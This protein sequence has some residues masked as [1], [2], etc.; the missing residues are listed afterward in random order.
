M[1][2]KC[3]LP[4]LVHISSQTTAAWRGPMISPRAH[5]AAPQARSTSRSPACH[6]AAPLYRTRQGRMLQPSQDVIQR[7]VLN[8]AQSQQLLPQDL[9]SNNCHTAAPAPRTPSTKARLLRAIHAVL[10]PAEHAQKSL[11]K[12]KVKALTKNCCALKSKIQQSTVRSSQCST[13]LRVSLTKAA[14]ASGRN[15]LHYNEFNLT[16]SS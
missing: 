8:S 16:S 4:Q 5:M 9:P 3:K 2:E 14:T 11:Q 13:W 15:L 10:P 6:F 1:G 7:P 12:L